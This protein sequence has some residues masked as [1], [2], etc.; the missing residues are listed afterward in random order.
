M[1]F[2]SFC[3]LVVSSASFSFW[4]ASSARSFSRRSLD[5]ASSS[6][7]SAI[8]SISSRRTSRS[9]SSTSTGRESISIRSRLADLVDQVDGLV[10]QEPGGDVAVGQRRG[11]HQRGVGDAHTVVHLVAV[12]QPT[13]DADGVL[14]R[15]LT[16]EHLLEA[17]L[18]CGVLLDVLAV[19]VE[20][21]GA[22]Q[23]QLAAGQHRLDHV[24]GIH[25]RLTGRAGPDDGV[26]L[27]D[28]GDD[29]PGGV[30]DVVEHGLEPFLEF[31]AVLGAGHHRTQVQAD[32]GLVAQALG[33]VAGD[34][35]L[36]QALHD[37][38]LTD[39]GLADQHRVVLGATGEHLHDAANLVVP[40]D[41]R[42]ELAFAGAGG[43]VGGVLLQRLIGGLGVGAGDAGAAADLDERVAQRLRR[44][45]VSG[46]QLGDVGVAG[47][48]PDHQVLGGDVFVVHLGGQLLRGGDGGQRF[49]RQLRLRAGAAGLRQP[50]QDA[51]R[52][53]ADSGGLD[54]DSLQQRRGDPV[55]LRQQRQ[56]Q[57]SRPDLGVAGGGRRLQG[58]CQ[59]RLRLGCRVERVHDTSVQGQRGPKGPVKM[60]VGLF[61]AVKVESVP[62]KPRYLPQPHPQ[63]NTKIWCPDGNT[64]HT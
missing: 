14:H 34:D 17:P 44:G 51:L 16:D 53:G 6:L 8:S 36:G 55:V 30:L 11:G 43:Q 41:D 35:A 13:Q 2:F 56:Q 28:E 64:I 40:P 32:D 22:D 29:L 49:A 23:P 63:R 59:G 10:R 62:L 48:Q 39:A 60:L 19:L 5:A 37:R 46:Q 20:R 21:G 45:A 1:A 27:V 25:R 42:V 50:V 61:N 58:R 57:M 9:T 12:L 38:G 4:S 33:H 26:Q 31:A 15:R 3:H 18:Q 54:A 47:G 52:F 24:A 7:A